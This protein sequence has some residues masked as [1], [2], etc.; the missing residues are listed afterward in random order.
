[1]FWR[2]EISV[3]REAQVSKIQIARQTPLISLKYIDGGPGKKGG[4]KKVTNISAAA[5]ICI[6]ILIISETNSRNLRT[7]IDHTSEGG[8]KL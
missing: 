4:K 7:S 5:R 2:I 6:I 1:M 8:Q 3:D